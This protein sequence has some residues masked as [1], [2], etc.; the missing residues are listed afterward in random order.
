MKKY[1]YHDIDYFDAINVINIIDGLY[2]PLSSVCSKDDCMSIIE[3]YKLSNGFLFPFPITISISPQTTNLLKP[4]MLRHDGA[5]IAVFEIQ[6]IFDLTP[7]YW[8]KIFQTDELSHPG[9]K[10]ELNRGSIRL[11]GVLKPAGSHAD[12]PKISNIVRKEIDDRNWSKIGSFQTRNPP[13]RGHEHLIRI[14][15]ETNDGIIITPLYGWKKKDDF[16]NAVIASGFHALID[17]YLNKKNIIYHPLTFNMNYAGPRDAILHGVIR[18]NIGATSMI[19]G[20]D[21][22]GVGNFY[23]KYAAHDLIKSLG[24]RPIENFEFSLLAEPKY[25]HSCGHYVSDKTCRHL[26]EQSSI[27][28]TLI[29]SLVAK[30]TQP[31]SWMMRPE[32]WNSINAQ[33]NSL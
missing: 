26:S 22:A 25:C 32:V 1:E 12:R 17:N 8:Y 24:P 28:G 33:E 4:I 11:S 29:R 14:A 3:D 16:S 30:K 27:S 10:R 5:D 9:L 20:R 23:D 13:H 7:S 6:D 21:H 19:V 31:Q 15:L 2:N 18:H